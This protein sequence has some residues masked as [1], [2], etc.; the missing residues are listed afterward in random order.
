MKTTALPDKKAWADRLSKEAKQ[1]KIKKK[2][3]AGESGLSIPTLAT[4]LDG[5]SSYENMKQVEEALSR[6]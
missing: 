4:V 1:K 5:Y 6:L 3:L 2:I